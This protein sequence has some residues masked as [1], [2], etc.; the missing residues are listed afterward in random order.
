MTKDRVSMTEHAVAFD[1]AGR[2]GTCKDKMAQYIDD[3][4]SGGRSG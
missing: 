1:D 4:V 3:P 2:R